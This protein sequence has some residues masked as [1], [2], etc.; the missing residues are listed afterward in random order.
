VAS[1]EIKP[2][3]KVA[4]CTTDM[5]CVQSKVTSKNE[6]NSQNVQKFQHVFTMSLT[7]RVFWIIHILKMTE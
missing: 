3:S 2:A 6:E 1:C 7:K 5:Y 4:Y